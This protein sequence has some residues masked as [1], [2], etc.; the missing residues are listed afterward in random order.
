[1]RKQ[2][3]GRYECLT[4]RIPMSTNWWSYNLPSLRKDMLSLFIRYFDWWLTRIRLSFLILRS[5]S[6]VVHCRRHGYR[7]RRTQ[8]CQASVRRCDRAENRSFRW[9]PI[10]FVIT[11]IVHVEDSL[12]SSLWQ[13]IC[14]IGVSG[15]QQSNVTIRRR[16]SIEDTPTVELLFRS[17]W[18]TRI[19]SSDAEI[20]NIYSNVGFINRPSFLSVL[21][22]WI[23]HGWN[24]SLWLDLDYVQ[25]RHEIESHSIRIRWWNYSS[26]SNT[27]RLRDGRWWHHRCIL[28]PN[29]YSVVA[30]TDGTVDTKIEEQR[31]SLRRRFG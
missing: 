4:D 20:E 1:M 15:A 28:S 12:L 7:D 21:Q 13:F 29:A 18:I 25:T 9:T 11:I 17:A 2:S 3:N 6:I 30:R 8:L 26:S 23:L 19:L 27:D 22:T 14:S 10:D 24:W 16:Q 31:N 5:S